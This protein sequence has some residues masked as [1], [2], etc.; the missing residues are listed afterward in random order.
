[1]SVANLSVQFT[2]RLYPEELLLVLL[3]AS[4]LVDPRATVWPGG[5]N[6]WKIKNDNIGNRNRDLAASSATTYHAS[7]DTQITNMSPPIH[8]GVHSVVLSF[9]VVD[10]WQCLLTFEGSSVLYV[11][12]M[13][14]AIQIPVIDRNLPT[15]RIYSL[16]A[17]LVAPWKLSQLFPHIHLYLSVKLHIVI[18]FLSPNW[19]TNFLFIYI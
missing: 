7:W 4:G 2:V 1:M 5:L 12:P 3:P 19:C 17:F 13:V 9:S 6:Q 15:F 8:N 11:T 14:L 10:S 18:T 16:L